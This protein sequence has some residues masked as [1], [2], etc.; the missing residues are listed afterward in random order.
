MTAEIFEKSDEKFYNDGANYWSEIPATVD[1]MLGGFGFVSQIDIKDSK[2]LLKHLFNSKVPPDRQYALDCGAGIGR[3]TKFLLTDLFEKVDLVEQNPVFLEQAKNYMG[4]KISKVI[5]FYPEGLQHFHP[6]P[7]KYDVI[8]IQWVLGH[9]TDND[10][11]NFLLSCQDGLRPNGVII[12][13]ENITSTDDI[14]MDRQ[15]SSVTRPMW[16]FRR[17]FDKANLECYRQVK[18]RNFP[19][20]LYSVYMFVLKPRKENSLEPEC[21]SKVPLSKDGSETTEISCDGSNIQEEN[22]DSDNSS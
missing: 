16:L 14:E 4:N 22:R 1:G 3:I 7:M 5:N 15:D 2:M 18:Q 20:G 13:K 21:I 8:W 19:K 11:I 10:L 17:I 6:Q 12:V 9:L